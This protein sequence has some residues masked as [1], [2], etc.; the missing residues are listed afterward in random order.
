MNEQTNISNY[1]DDTTFHT[2]DQ[3]LKALLQRLEHDSA[4][5]IEWFEAN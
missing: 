4:L 2:S 3:I 5:A 1:A